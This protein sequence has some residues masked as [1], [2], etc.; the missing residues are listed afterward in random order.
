ML[1]FSCEYYNNFID[2]QMLNVNKIVFTFK[3]WSHLNE[4]CLHQVTLKILFVLMVLLELFIYHDNFVFAFTSYMLLHAMA[5][6]N[7][8][9]SQ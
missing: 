4:Y 8:K 5:F 2:V 7:V 1:I 3:C 6:Q 9:K